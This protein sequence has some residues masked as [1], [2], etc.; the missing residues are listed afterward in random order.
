VVGV[1]LAIRLAG[2]GLR[3]AADLDALVLCYRE[4]ELLTRVGLSVRQR[5]AMLAAFAAWSD[6]RWIEALSRAREGEA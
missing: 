1:D 4:D 3:T 6:P 2:Y 5:H